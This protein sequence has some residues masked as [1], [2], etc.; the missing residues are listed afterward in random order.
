MVDTAAICLSKMTYASKSGN[1]TLIRSLY[2][3][4]SNLINER[5]DDYPSDAH[6]DSY[7][8]ANTFHE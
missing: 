1:P 5:G 7:D 4:F 3:P 8:H 2:M 6:L